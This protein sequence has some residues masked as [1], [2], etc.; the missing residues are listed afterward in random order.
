MYTIKVLSDKEFDNLPQTVTRGS[1]ISD[2]LGFAN[3]FRGEAFVR[4]TGHPELQK[5]LIDHE[6]EELVEGHE[7]HEDEN[8]IRHKKFRQVIGGLAPIV[9]PILG[10]AIPGLGPVLGSALGGAAGGAL[11]GGIGG[12][13]RSLGGALKGGA[14]G[15]ALG[16]AGGK[17]TGG[18]GVGTK[19]TGGSFLGNFGSNLATQAKSAFGLKNFLG[20]TSRATQA[21]SQ[22]SSTGTGLPGG[23]PLQSFGLTPS[24]SQ[25]SSIPGLSAGNASFNFIG[26]QNPLGGNSIRDFGLGG[27]EQLQGAGFNLPPISG[28]TA[29]QIPQNPQ[30]AQFQL[31]GQGGGS[32][33]TPPGAVSRNVGKA[34][35]QT[36]AQTGTGE[37]QGV[38]EKAFGKG[39]EFFGDPQNLLGTALLG[40]G[41]LKQFPEAPDISAQTQQLRQQVGGGPLGEQARGVLS[42]NL[43]RQFEPLSDEEITAVTRDIDR[44]E[45]EAKERVRETF[46][47]VRPG[48]SELTDTALAQELR[49]VEREF[50]QLREDAIAGRTRTAEDRFRS[51]QLADIQTAIGASD[52]EFNQLAQIAQLDV[53]Q[54]AQQ[55]QLDIEQAQLFKETMLGLG[56]RALFPQ[57]TLADTLGQFKGVL[58]GNE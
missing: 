53:N 46:R 32:G 18:F 17:L 50:A 2:S 16:A 45:E 35:A 51:Q 37:A 27:R 20:G 29:P 41:L 31:A 57:P 1:D 43:D 14:I 40:G 47:N 42:Q 3:P 19:A 22:L 36:G 13:K 7:G 5:Y 44:Q 11:R 25:I 12:D 26:S 52:Q 24:A 8:G 58:G 39:K 10:A 15:G 21:G 49:N 33:G 28:G 4:Y 34:G 55:L 54:I 48:T 56:Q 9:A 23:L 6:F 38:L 30:T